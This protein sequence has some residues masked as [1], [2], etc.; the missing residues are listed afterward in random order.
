[1]D[2]IKIGKSNTTDSV[3]INLDSA[4]GGG[5]KSVNFG[6]G[7]GMLMNEKKKNKA[8]EVSNISINDI[9]NLESDLDLGNININTMSP[10]EVKLNIDPTPISSTSKI[11]ENMKSEAPD[12][13]SFNNIPI[14]PML[15]VPKK[16][17][18]TKEEQ[19]REKFEI[20]RKLEALEK[21]GIRL[22]KKYGMESSLD[23]MKGE[24]EMVKK[25]IEKKN[26]I[27][28][29]GKMLMAC[30]TGL[31]FLNNKFDPFDLKLD[32]WAEAIN[33]NVDE[34]DDVF[35]EL[36][37]KYASKAKMAPEIKLLFMLG[38]SAAMLHMTNTMFKSSMPGMDDIMRQ[39]PELM[40]QFTQ[41][42][43]NTMS[44]DN[45]GFGNFMNNT[46]PQQ[47]QQQ[48]M[49]PRG[50]PPGPTQDMRT[51]PPILPRKS[52]KSSRIDVGMTRGQ[53]KFN[54]AENMDSNYKSIPSNRSKSKRKEMKGPQDIGDILS[55]LKTKNV[56]VKDTS[57]TISLE[58]LKELNSTNLSMPKKSKKSK[59]TPSNV[60][61]LNI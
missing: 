47:Q 29:Q 38:G 26:S 16:K 50:S 18:Q 15:N 45:P 56:K 31:E 36:H 19:L 52:S 27:K 58:E 44:N 35:S 41:A 17:V 48:P 30:I 34:Y 43:V 25:D 1:M 53:A 59:R 14:D 49:P 7:I 13:T 20:L 57:S 28:F 3:S 61:N 23:E 9:N 10:P 2:S 22:S 11:G 21:K 33:E 55:G 54:D 24:Y 12:M 39:N 42:A 46:R 8:E 37:E 60:V 6:P 32:G 51:V 40:H 4:R 5:T